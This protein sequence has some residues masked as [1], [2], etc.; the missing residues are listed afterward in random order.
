MSAVANDVWPVILSNKLNGFLV[1][2]CTIN[3]PTATSL[4]TADAP[5]ALMIVS[6]PT[7]VPTILVIS[8]FVVSR[9]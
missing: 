4:I 8:I 7:N 2:T 1:S 5:D 3:S 9:M 6:P